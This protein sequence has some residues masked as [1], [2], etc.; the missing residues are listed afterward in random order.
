MAGTKN[1]G[2]V[3]GLFIGTSAPS[4][5]TLIW[6]D[7]TPAIK[8]HKVYSET[9][10][11]WVVLD[12]TVISAITYSVLSN[13]A[14]TTGLTIGQWFKIT[15]KNNVLALAITTTKVQYTDTLGNVVV[16][17][18]G[19]NQSYIV[20]S[21]NLLIDDIAGVY[22]TTNNKLV[23]SFDDV[24][25]ANNTNYYL[26]G[27]AKINNVW[28]LA[29]YKMT[30]FLSTVSGNSIS[31]NNG[32]F[33]NFLSNLSSYYDTA[34]G[35]VSKSAYDTQIASLTQQITNAANNIQN[36]SSQATA[37]V[38][39]ATTAA[40]IYS[41]QLPV[42]PTAATPV[43]IAQY[44]TLQTIVIKV[45]RWIQKFKYATGIGM[46]S[47]YA[48][49]TTY[50]PVSNTDNVE[51]A[52]GKL[53]LAVRTLRT[54]QAAGTDDVTLASGY[55]DATHHTLTPG[56]S[57]LTDVLEE[58]SFRISRNV[59]PIFGIIA[60]HNTPTYDNIYTYAGYGWFPCGVFFYGTTANRIAEIQK[61][62]NTY[63]QANVNITNTTV[64]NDMGYLT[65]VSVVVN[66]STRP[67]PNLSQK[68]VRGYNASDTNVNIGDTGGNSTHT[69]VANELPD[70]T[71]TASCSSDGE[72]NHGGN[73]GNT[74][75]TFSNGKVTITGWA[76]GS[77]G[78]NK[79]FQYS[80][81]TESATHADKDYSVTGG[82]VSDHSH[83]ISNSGT[84]AHT[85]TVNGGSTG[86]NSF[87]LLPP[88]SVEAYLIRL[89]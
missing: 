39:A 15:D 87:S 59:Q 11:Q 60:W 53:A 5:T 74:Q 4:N 13:L 86:N 2:Q 34:G 57:D 12:N 16:D 25:P 79:E 75:P 73:T 45:Y 82:T 7:S 14:Q 19:H 21:S 33:L 42:A 43:D 8:C 66:G 78:Y 61:W 22:D 17:D 37:A 29:K 81:A 56:T 50:S 69:I 28:K 41:K 89:M 18:L 77:T 23:F 30:T 49:A 84:H 26:L 3:A 31:W 1:L 47:S 62:R 20:S 40:Q 76:S 6:Y 71:H 52:I 64:G 83:T 65:F 88:Y 9:L 24:I 72:H 80:N 58:L 67:I 10:S 70:H 36:V 32:F 38:T 63:G 35:V 46:S 27:K 48:E 68:F 51:T 54:Q 85:I 55:T 44:D